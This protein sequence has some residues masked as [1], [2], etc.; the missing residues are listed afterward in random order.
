M[1][2]FRKLTA[3]EQEKL[4]TILWTIFDETYAFDDFSEEE[5]DEESEDYQSWYS[6]KVF[7][8][9]ASTLDE[10]CECFESVSLDYLRELDVDSIF[11]E[12][13]LRQIEKDS[14]ARSIALERFRAHYGIDL[15]PY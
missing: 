5:P 8:E 1:N 12:A 4:R 15:Q 13:F 10:F 3:D 7:I 9:D 11:D 2:N 14:G 6:R